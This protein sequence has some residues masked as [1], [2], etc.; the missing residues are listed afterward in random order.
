M[1]TFQQNC[2]GIGDWWHRTVDVKKVPPWKCERKRVVKVNWHFYRFA[3]SWLCQEEAPRGNQHGGDRHRV[4]AGLQHISRVWLQHI[5]NAAFKDISV[6]G[7]NIFLMQHCMVAIYFCGWLQ[8]ISSSGLKIIRPDFFLWDCLP[9]C[10]SWWPFL[11]QKQD[12]SA[13]AI[14]IPGVW[15]NFSHILRFISPDQPKCDS[16]IYPRT[17]SF[18]HVSQFTSHLFQFMSDESNWSSQH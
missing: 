5:S 8:Y 3:R 11:Q 13:T 9:W 7:C 16:D 4:S 6:D 12:I 10:M 18:A 14:D 17:F 15:H 2:S 1:E